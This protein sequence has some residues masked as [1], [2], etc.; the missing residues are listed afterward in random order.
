MKDDFFCLSFILAMHMENL[1]MVNQLCND[2][3]VENNW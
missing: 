1:D 3:A 2:L